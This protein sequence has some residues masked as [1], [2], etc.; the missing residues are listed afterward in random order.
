MNSKIKTILLT[1]VSFFVVLFVFF[2]TL[3]ST[4]PGKSLLVR[5]ISHKTDSKLSIEKL[6]LT[7]LGPQQLDYVYFSNERKRVSFDHFYGD[8]KL[9]EFFKL[10]HLDFQP[11]LKCCKNW[12]LKNGNYHD[13]EYQA[14]IERTYGSGSSN[15]SPSGSEIAFRLNA[16]VPNKKKEGKITLTGDLSSKEKKP[17]LEDLK[18][19]ILLQAQNIPSYFFPVKDR[20]FSK[21]LFGDLFSVTTKIDWQKGKKPLLV[22]FQSDNL[23]TDF[24]AFCETGV[25]YLSQEVTLHFTVTDTLSKYVLKDLHPLFFHGLRSINPAFAIIYPEKVQFP[26]LPFVWEKV[27]IPKAVL[28]M[29]QIESR[30]RGLVSIILNLLKARSFFS[31]PRLTLWFAPSEFSVK[32]YDFHMK[33]LDF[34]VDSNLHFFTG[35]N[36]DW[37]TDQLDLFFGVPSSTL[38]NLFKI[39]KLPKDACL[40]FSIN[41]TPDCPKIDSKEIAAKVASLLLPAKL[42]PQFSEFLPKQSS[43]KIPPPKLPFPWDSLKQE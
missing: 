32:G 1:I 9:W 39:K 25:L 33:R 19:E 15:A 27:C 30:N 40:S 4:K 37:K 18:G 29:G 38:K 10:F 43:E 5:V 14:S 20:N 6:S 35:G 36:V 34:L 42:A 16:E 21:A 11:L 28:H 31:F 17:S 41:G 22:S 13:K 3:L 24:H 23:H 26:L 2:P 7:W 12:E 8:L